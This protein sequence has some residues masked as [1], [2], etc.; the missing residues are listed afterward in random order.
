MPGKSKA[1]DA[2][3]MVSE[4]AIRQRAYYLWEADGRP[5]GQGDHYWG[6]AHAEATK[7]LA[8]LKSNG[9]AKAAKAKA[10]AKAKDAKPV[11]LKAAKATEAKSVKKAATKPRAAVKAK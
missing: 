10:P 11:K 8:A 9:S 1:A 3:A 5:D 6:L 2:A 7:V 4:D